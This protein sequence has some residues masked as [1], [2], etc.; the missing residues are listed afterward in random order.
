M[1][2]PHSKLKNAE[3]NLRETIE[4]FPQA[5]TMINMRLKDAYQDPHD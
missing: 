2:D 4:R 1:V 5:K 3:A